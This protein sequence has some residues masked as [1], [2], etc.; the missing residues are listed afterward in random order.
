MTFV[1]YSVIGYYIFI[2]RTHNQKKKFLPP[3]QI[4]LHELIE[5]YSDLNLF[6]TA[7]TA[8]DPGG[9]RTLGFEAP[10][11]SI[12]GLYFIFPYFFL[13]HFAWHIISLIFYF[14]IV[15]IQKFSSLT[16]L[17]I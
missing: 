9:P 2:I 3:K 17:G 15:Q 5:K 4:R 12:F 16:S 10:R 14:F 13:P 1:T 6:I 8:A 11:L 7:R